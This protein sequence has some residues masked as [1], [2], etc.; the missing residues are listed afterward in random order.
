[1]GHARGED[2]AWEA[3]EVEDG[4]E[5][6]VAADEGGRCGLEVGFG[7]LGFEEESGGGSGEGEVD[8]GAVDCFAGWGFFRARFERGVEWDAGSG[9]EAG[10]GGGVY[11]E[12]RGDRGGEAGAIEDAWVA[13]DVHQQRVG[14]GGGVELHPSPVLARERAAGCGVRLGEAAEPV[15]VGADGRVGG[16]MEVAVAC[17]LVGGGI[18]AAEEDGGIGAGGDVV[19]QGVGARVVG[20]SGGE[21]A[22]ELGGGP[23]RIAGRRLR[24]R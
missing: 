15:G 19:E 13:E 9:S 22:A 21:V 23:V 24:H 10:C 5:V 6:P 8:L 18:F 7:E 12:E 20:G 3:I 11:V 4:F 14:T 17:G 1:M 16:G 2:L